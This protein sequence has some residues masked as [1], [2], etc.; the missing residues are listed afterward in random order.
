MS[1]MPARQPR[2]PPKHPTKAGAVPAKLRYPHETRGLG[3]FRESVLRLISSDASPL[4][5]C[6]AP[7]V[8][9]FEKKREAVTAAL[10]LMT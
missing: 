10:P 5:V 3:P 1:V 6:G 7:P 8:H 4:I 9:R 2:V